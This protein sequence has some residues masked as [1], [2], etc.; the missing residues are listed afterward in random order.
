MTTTKIDDYNNIAT[1]ST[2]DKDK[3]NNYNFSMLIHSFPAT[4]MV[5]IIK[6]KHDEY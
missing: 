6:K 2:S 3:D 4:I 1:T 5:V